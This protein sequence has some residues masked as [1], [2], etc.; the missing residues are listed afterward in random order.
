MLDICDYFSFQSAI[1]LAKKYNVN[2][3]VDH[4][5]KIAAFAGD[6]FDKTKSLHKLDKIYRNLLC[7]SAIIHDIGCFVNKSKH[8]KH[9]KYIILSDSKL[10]GIPEYLRNYIAIIS[11]SHRKSID[12]SIQIYNKSI[13]FKLK[14]LISILRIADSLDHTHRLNNTLNNIL[15]SEDYLIFYINSDDFQKTLV[16]FNIKNQLF[17]EIFKVNARLEPF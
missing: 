16:K 13:Q 3:V 8:H 7:C 2:K 15:L 5:I 6:I 17:N 14:V 1:Y 4:E 12:K 10:D 9:S 11:S